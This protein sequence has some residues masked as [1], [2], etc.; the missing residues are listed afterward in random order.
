MSEQLAQEAANFAADYR[1][2]AVVLCKQV[3]TTHQ[4]ACAL[5]L[6]PEDE[7]TYDPHGVTLHLCNGEPWGHHFYGNHTRKEDK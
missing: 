6:G 3:C 2:Q 7:H 1:T 4:R 5:R